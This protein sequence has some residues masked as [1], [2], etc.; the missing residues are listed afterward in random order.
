MDIC[1]FFGVFS[2]RQRTDV[3]ASADLD[4]FGREKQNNLQFTEYFPSI[5]PLATDVVDI[6]EKLQLKLK[7]SSSWHCKNYFDTVKY[8]KIQ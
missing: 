3:R 8:S 1:F 7:P 4:F 2:L 5:F 6:L